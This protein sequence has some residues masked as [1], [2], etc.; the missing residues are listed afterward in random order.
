MLP[1]LVLFEL[2]VLIE[3]K[4]FIKSIHGGTKM[5]IMRGKLGLVVFKKGS[6]MLSIVLDFY[7]LRKLGLA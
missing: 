6:V 5:I 3:L 7:I 4:F 2:Y 1:N